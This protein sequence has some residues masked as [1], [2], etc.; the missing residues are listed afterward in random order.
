MDRTQWLYRMQIVPGYQYPGNLVRRFCQA[1]YSAEAINTKHIF[2]LKYSAY[3]YSAARS[4]QG[5]NNHQ[6]FCQSIKNAQRT[7]YLTMPSSKSTPRQPKLASFSSSR[8]KTCAGMTYGPGAAG[9]MGIW[10]LLGYAMKSQNALRV[11]PK[12]PSR[13][14][15]FPSRIS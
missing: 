13:W 6:P 2:I 9:A 15:L 7:L 11:S 14:P 3:T 4:P 12:Q 8:I 1:V 5:K 10:S